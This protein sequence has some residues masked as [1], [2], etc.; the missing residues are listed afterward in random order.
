MRKNQYTKT[1]DNIKAPDRAVRRAV[2]VIQN[3]NSK[4]E[5]FSMNQKLRFTGICAASLAAVL[6]IGGVVS[7]YGSQL[8]SN[9][10][11]Q[12]SASSTADSSVSKNS[13]VLTVNAAELTHEGTIATSSDNMNS[14]DIHTSRFSGITLSEGAD[15]VGYTLPMPVS[16]KGE[17]IKSVTYSVDFGAISVN[18]YKDENPVISGN[19]TDRCNN[20]PEYGVPLKEEYREWAKDLSAKYSEV[21]ENEEV[22]FST[23]E[24]EKI[25]AIEK[26]FEDIERK[27]YSTVT[28]DYSN[29]GN[30]A[31]VT[32]VGLS[33]ELSEQDQKYLKEHNDELFNFYSDQSLIEAK[34]ICLDKLFGN[35]II[36]CTIT[37]NDG[38]QQ[39][40]DIKVGTA[41]E[42]FENAYADGE[43][44]QEKAQLLP[45]EEK[46][47]KDVFATY[48]LA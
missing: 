44:Y 4:K 34:K 33:T 25:A 48:S 20:T 22:S 27:H 16:C 37:F 42:T 9:S 2:Y 47:A 1:I 40:Q 43:V 12:T 32:L 21:K 30:N 31:A 3:Q 23:E 13:F 18:Y 17:N 28:F 10:G 24:Q 39:T 38:T 45:E 46:N 41:I 7:I 6:A 5:I 29:Q 36:H 15:G 11:I 14:A 35:Q 19:E 8:T 26:S